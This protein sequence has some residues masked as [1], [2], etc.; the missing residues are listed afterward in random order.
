MPSSSP[1]PRSPSPDSKSAFF[2]YWSLFFIFFSTHQKE[3][4]LEGCAWTGLRS[5]EVRIF[6]S[7]KSHFHLIG[8]PCY[9]VM[10]VIIITISSSLTS[11]WTTAIDPQAL[12]MV[13]FLSGDSRGHD[14]ITPRH[15]TCQIVTRCSFLGL[16]GEVGGARRKGSTGNEEEDVT[17]KDWTRHKWFSFPRI[18]HYPYFCNSSVWLS[19]CISPKRSRSDL[20]SKQTLILWL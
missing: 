5:W 11:F 1:H 2:F 4:G 3:Q 15:I 8:A 13:S 9:V 14:I 17:G 19:I 18:P 7:P 6:S 10:V 16:D 20:I 12:G